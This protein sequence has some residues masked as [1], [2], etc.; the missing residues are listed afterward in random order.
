MALA[1][2]ADLQAAIADFLNRS[3]LTAAIPTFISLAEVQMTRRLLANGPVRQMMAR[4]DATISTE[5]CV[6][7]TDF[8]G[9]HT[10]YLVESQV[11]QLDYATPAQINE[12]KT[13]TTQLT[14]DP[15]FFSVVG[16][17][18]QF[19]PAPT[20]AL[21]A[22]LTYWQRIPALS[23][24]NTTNWLMTLYPDAYLYGALLQSAPYL[25][26]DTRIAVWE[27][28]FGTILDDVVSVSK[29]ENSN[30]FITVPDV[31]GTTP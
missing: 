20:A 25:Q 30:P 22:E 21:A 6:V 19:F 23:T 1:V 15:K 14:G 2:Y 26:A 8:I 11:R 13:H 3:D 7:P 17:E 31:L 12:K 18:F 16:G 28:A 24:T 9:A 29:V 10:I 27:N 5:Y 4:A